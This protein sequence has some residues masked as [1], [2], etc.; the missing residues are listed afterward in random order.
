MQKTTEEIKKQKK[1]VEKLRNEAKKPIIIK[2]KLE[3]N[4]GDNG[5]PSHDEL[6][7]LIRQEKESLT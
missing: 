5:I 2:T 3:D 1:E 7:D 4:N 6:I